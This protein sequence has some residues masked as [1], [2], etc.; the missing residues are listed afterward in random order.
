MTSLKRESGYII[1]DSH[2]RRIELNVCAEAKS[3]CANGAGKHFIPV[4]PVFADYGVPGKKPTTYA[5]VCGK[6]QV[7]SFT[8]NVEGL[9][10]TI[11]SEL[12]RKRYRNCSKKSNVV[13][14]NSILNLKWV[15]FQTVP[16]CL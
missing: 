2:N 6:L 16:L 12:L 4:V 3:S 15:Y 9:K 8:G 7:A 13:L 5:Q 1:S 14:S 10:R 11:V